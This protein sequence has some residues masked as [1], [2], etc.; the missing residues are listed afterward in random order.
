MT[1]YSN[2]GKMILKITHKLTSDL[3]SEPEPMGEFNRVGLDQIGAYSLSYDGNTFLF[4]SRRSPGI[5]NFDIFMTER[6]GD[7]WTTPKNLG[8]PV[9][10]ETNDGFPFLAADNKTL[11]FAR[12]KKMDLEKCSDCSIYQV[13]KKNSQYWNM[14]EEITG[15]APASDISA[16]RI[17]M[18][19]ETLV[20]AAK[21]PGNKGG[22]DLYQQNLNQLKSKPDALDYLNTPGDDVF[23]SIPTTGEWAYFSTIFRERYNLIVAQV[24]ENLRPGKV[25]AASGKITDHHQVP[26]D[27]VVK[28][29]DPMTGKVLNFART[30]QDG[31][32]FIVAKLSGQL[33]ITAK[34]LDD[35][36]L[37][38]Y[39]RFRNYSDQSIYL[40]LDFDLRPLKPRT[41]YESWNF[42]FQP[43]SAALTKSSEAA[44]KRWLE[45]LRSNHEFKM[46]MEVYLPEII[47]DTIPSCPELTEIKIDTIY[48]EVAD[49]LIL[50][51]LTAEN[52]TTTGLDTLNAMDSTFI[53]TELEVEL[54]VDLTPFDLEYTYHND[55]T[56]AMAAAIKAELLRLGVPENAFTIIGNGDQHGLAIENF[57][58]GSLVRIRFIP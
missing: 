46:E 47:S 9:N 31:H 6:K 36:Y 2:N 21:I 54:P 30:D 16:P 27:A 14:P 23:I 4:T 10:S 29:S 38:A 32:Y 41:T 25:L 20:F 1:N 39:H 53:P 12:C 44:I 15:L 34:A 22:Y 33:D 49:S 5:G 24:P 40:P 19:H 11:Y 28:I 26:M 50:A 35:S 57:K 48:H 52:D 43:C 55:R 37:F 17:M 18:D 58:E 42:D 45:V 51:N 3:W 8:K 13:T 7:K 56:P